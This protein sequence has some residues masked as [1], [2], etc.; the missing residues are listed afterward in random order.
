MLNIYRSQSRGRSQNSWLDSWHSFSFG[1]YHHPQRTGFGSL[2]VINQDIVAPGKGFAPHSHNDMEIVT[3]VLEGALAHKDSVGNTATIKVGDVQRMSAGTGITHSE[4]NPN[5]TE[6]AHFLQLW[7]LPKTLGIRPSYEQKT[8]SRQEKSGR[9][10]LLACADGREGSLL[11]HQD[12]DLR[13]TLLDGHPPVTY[14]P[15]Q[16][17]VQWLQLAKGS[18]KLNDVS[19]GAGDGV[20]ITNESLL[21]I[22]DAQAAELLLFD[23]PPAI[24]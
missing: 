5:E 23:M 3:Y 20:A 14:K 9:L 13:A 2:R 1:N 16:E 7:F 21:T 6:T 8:F 4:Y 17:N 18:L 19:L 10:T 24:V 15:K 11:I 22:S 12:V